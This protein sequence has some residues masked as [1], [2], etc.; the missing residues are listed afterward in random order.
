[1]RPLVK[2]TSTHISR[3]FTKGIRIYD[4]D[5]NIEPLFTDRLR[6]NSWLLLALFVA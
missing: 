6:R 3:T 2:N 1:M 5:P 4:T